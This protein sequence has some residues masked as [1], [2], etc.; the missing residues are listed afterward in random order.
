MDVAW[1]RLADDTELRARLADRIERFRRRERLSLAD[2]SKRSGVGR[3]TVQRLVKGS[4]STTLATV[5]K[6]ADCLGI[7]PWELLA[8]PRHR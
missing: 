4:D 8:P 3:S 7:E 2:F 5:A 1:R 6:V